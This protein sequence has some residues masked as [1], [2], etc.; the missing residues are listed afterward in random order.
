MARILV[1]EDTKAEQQLISALLN[2]AGFQV[3]TADNAEAAWQWLE[4]NQLPD[5]IL[6]DIIMPGESG[7]EL[8]RRIRDNQDWSKVPILFCSS[9]S[10]DFDRF[11]AIRQGGNDY[12]TKPFAPQDLVKA[13]FQYAQ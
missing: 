12:I 7:L 2:H 4:N 1:V 11:W 6:L 9:K 10:E 8:C 3:F 5:L 13:V